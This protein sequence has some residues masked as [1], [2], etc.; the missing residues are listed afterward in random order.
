MLYIYI[1][2][3]LHHLIFLKQVVIISIQPNFGASLHILK[4]EIP[5]D[6]Q[7]T[8]SKRNKFVSNDALIDCC[9]F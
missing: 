2:Y 7:T 4:V 8:G 3:V 6:A 9:D 5:G 1:L